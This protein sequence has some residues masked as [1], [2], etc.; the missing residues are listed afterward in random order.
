MM[1]PQGTLL[2]ISSN[3]CSQPVEAELVN[4]S[5]AGGASPKMRGFVD[6]SFFF[7]PMSIPIGWVHKPSRLFKRRFN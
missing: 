1:Q 7:C 5:L 2:Y 6:S 4:V 3:L